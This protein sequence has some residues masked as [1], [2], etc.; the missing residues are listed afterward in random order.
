MSTKPGE[1]Q[2]QL[3]LHYLCQTKGCEQR[4]KSIRKEK[5]EGEFEV[6]LRDLKP[7]RGLF[8]VVTD[9]F[10]DLW[11]M[12][13]A[14]VGE[15]TEAM[16][17]ELKALSRKADQ[18]MDRLVDTSDAALVPAYEKKLRDLEL[19]KAEL[20]ERIGQCGRQLPDF[21]ETYRTALAFLANPWNLWASER[22]E[23]KRKVLRMAFSEPLRYD[24]N[25]GY[26]TADLTLPFKVLAG[27]E[28]EKMEM[29]P[30]VGLE[31]TTPALRMLCST[32]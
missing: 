26:R 4:S 10:H 15:R 30:P 9:M 6:L 16:K 1:L 8:N 28:S 19:R 27:I 2:L 24:R 13:R 29:V 31:P 25:T 21:R 7:T 11:E 12:H 5:L 32:N 18:L 14:G 17:S 3:Q 20:T 22:L 23:D